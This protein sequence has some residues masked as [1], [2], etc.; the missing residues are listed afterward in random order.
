MVFSAGLGMDEP[1]PAAPPATGGD[2]DLADDL[3]ALGPTFVKVGQLLSTRADLLPPEALRSLVAAA[4]R[5]DAVSL[6]G[7]RSDRDGGARRPH[8]EGV[9]ALRRHADRRRL[10]RPGPPRRAARRPRR[11]R[12]GPA[13]QHPRAGAPGPGDDGRSRG[14]SRQAHRHRPQPRSDA[15][16]R[17]VEAVA[18]ARARLPARSAEHGGN[19]RQPRGLPPPRRCRSRSTNTPRRAC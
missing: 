15:D 18:A 12:Q 19:R 16:G 6:R 13:S 11:G 7:R 14:A 2:K 8:L 4:G 3:E 10:A 5:R 9:L 17:R 1:D